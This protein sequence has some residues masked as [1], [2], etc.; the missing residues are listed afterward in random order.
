[1]LREVM[2]VNVTHVATI[3]KTADMTVAIVA[4]RTITERGG[5]LIPLYLAP[6]I[7]WTI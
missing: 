5:S 1:L 7:G 2:V 4:G 6:L 3:A